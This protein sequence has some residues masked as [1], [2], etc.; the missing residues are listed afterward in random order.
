[1][2]VPES[3]DVRNR[4]LGLFPAATVHEYHDDADATTKDAAIEAVVERLDEEGL[5]RLVVASFGLLHQHVF[6]FHWEPPED[7][8]LNPS[9]IFDEEPV[10]ENDVG[11]EHHYYY[12]LERNYQL[13]LDP[14]EKDEL[15]F[16]WPIK[17]VTADDHVRVHFTIMAK[18]PSA[19][20]NDNKTVVKSIPYPDEDKLLDDFHATDGLIGRA[21]RMDINRGIKALWDVDDIDSPNVKYKREKATSKDVMDESFTVKQDDPELYEALENKALFKTQFLLTV[22]DPCARYFVVNPS[23]GKVTF[24]RYSSTTDCVDSVIRRIIEAN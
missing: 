10:R 5:S 19:Y 7:E 15:V 8:G 9:E 3:T 24:R 17:V 12:L 18:S 13:Y 4:L 21:H 14:L 22:D 1:M 16:S 20:V 23:K 6:L 2:G 11:R